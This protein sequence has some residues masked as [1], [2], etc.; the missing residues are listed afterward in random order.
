MHESFSRRDFLLRSAAAASVAAL[1]ADAFS[2]AQAAAESTKMTIAQWSGSGT[3]S[4]AQIQDA[5]VKMTQQAI[6]GLGGMKRFVGRG[7]VV[8]IKPNIGWDRVPELACNTN[9][10]VVATLIRLAL[11]AG[12]KTVKVGDNPCDIAQKS[13][14]SSGIAEAA[15]K[16]GAEVVFLD[17]SRFREMDIRGERVKSL[18]V[19]PGIVECDL[20]INVP[21]IK[22]HGL[23]GATMCM[24][25]YMGVIEN[26]KL[27][28][29]DIPACLVDITRFMKPQICVLDAVRILTAH[30]PRGGDPNDVALKMTL[31]AGV[32][33]VALDAWGAEVLGR[34]PEEIKSVVKG[35]E[36]GLGT[37]DYRLL[38]PKEIAVS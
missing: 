35:S 32:D 23:A 38:S 31:A 33:P 27:F 12:A 18:P 17:R 29:Q 8:W 4:A 24:K 34:K 26:R 13:Y 9:P 6:E 15:K 2:T 25:N 16:L 36:A 37:M 11:D 3:P 10:D 19:F 7:S 1:G 5:A 21:I 14:A 22:H 28:H 20:V 30:G